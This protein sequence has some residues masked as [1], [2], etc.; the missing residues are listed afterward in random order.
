LSTFSATQL[1]VDND[2]YPNSN[3]VTP[4][5][6]ADTA[7]LFAASLR[8]VI[9]LLAART[10]P[11]SSLRQTSG[12]PGSLVAL[13]LALLWGKQEGVGLAMNRAIPG[14]LT[15]V[16]DAIGLSQYPPAPLRDQPVQVLHPAA[17]S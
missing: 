3:V 5:I 1:C 17:I 12:S 10:G 8:D 4:K 11:L 9:L 6:S 13:A 2:P 15:G 7:G 16:V 14:N